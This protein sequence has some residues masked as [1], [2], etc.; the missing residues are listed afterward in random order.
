MHDVAV[1]AATAGLPD[2]AHVDL[3]DGPGDGLAIGDLRLPD[4]RVDVEL[5]PEP[6]DDDV[7]VQLAHP[8]DDRLPGLFVE[9]HD[10]RRILIRQLAQTAAQLVLVGL[11]LRLHG[12]A[13]HGVGKLICSS[14]TG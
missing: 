2:E 5:A 9:A 7:E 6:V 10:E 3:V 14:T 8:R 13:D 11:G 4:V 12:D 1:L